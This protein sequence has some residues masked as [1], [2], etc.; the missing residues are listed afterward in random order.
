MQLVREGT[1]SALEPDL[2]SNEGARARPVLLRVAVIDVYVPIPCA[3][4]AELLEKLCSGEYQI[5]VD[6]AVERVPR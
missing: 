1:H 5:L 2:I 3:L 6:V 4:K